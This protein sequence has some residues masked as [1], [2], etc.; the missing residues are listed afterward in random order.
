MSYCRVHGEYSDLWESGCPECQRAE[1]RTRDAEADAA[2]AARELAE[3]V[4]E[5]AAEN[6]Y[7]SNNPGDF[8]CPYC[9]LISLKRG[10]RRCPKCQ[11][12]I[13]GQYW[14]ALRTRELEARK[15]EEA[16]RE[17]KRRAHEEW[18]RS[19]EGIAAMQGARLGKVG[20]SLVIGGLLLN[21]TS[22]VLRRTIGDERGHYPG[23][24]V[25]STIEVLSG[26]AGFAFGVAALV[27]FVTGR[28]R[29][30]VGKAVV[31]VLLGGLW[32][33]AAARAIA[34]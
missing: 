3:R 28:P 25:V 21:L 13:E 4:E 23:L 12:D 19:P 29:E 33:W 7:R 27:K 6:T 26:L 31:A 22:G 5:L 18:S 9:L 24:E 34:G 2:E 14:D 30:G 20:A 15:R 17:E 10:A 11:H 1:Q 32:V 16:A 8:E